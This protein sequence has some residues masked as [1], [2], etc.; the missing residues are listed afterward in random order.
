MSELPDSDERPA[1]LA[2]EPVSGPGIQT[3]LQRV[4]DAAAHVPDGEVWASVSLVEQH[5][6]VQTPVSSH[7]RAQ[8]AGPSPIR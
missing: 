5:R 6:E 3:T 2:R 4:V 8:R 1:A 7:H